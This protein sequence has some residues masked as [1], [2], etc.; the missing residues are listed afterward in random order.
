MN[1]AGLIFVVFSILAGIL[2]SGV[3]SGIYAYAQQSSSSGADSTSSISPELKAKLCDPTNPALKV[4]NTTEAHICGIPKTVKPS[5]AGTP[6]TS[7][8][9]SLTTQQTAKPTANNIV[10][11][12]TSKQQPITTTSNNAATT[13]AAIAPISNP[14]IKPLSSTTPIVAPQASQQQQL[15][16]QI[17][18]LRTINNTAVLNNTLPVVSPALNSGKLVFLGF[19]GD[20]TGSTPVGQTSTNTKS[21]SDHSSSHTNH[22]S[23]N[24]SPSHSGHS[25]TSHK[26]VS[27][28]NNSSSHSSKAPSSSSSSSSTHSSSSSSH[29]SKAT[30]SSS[31]ST[32][33]SSS[34]SSSSSS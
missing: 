26:N 19:H 21:H 7:A 13:S 17:L 16:P 10:S 22:S 31:S 29:S 28:H 24:N 27:N 25:S 30:S 12:P 34:S 33:S 9:S 2:I 15:K 32:H 3:W 11:G 4:V 1:Y 23:D 14:S 8:V 18:P 20:T 6:S 5:L